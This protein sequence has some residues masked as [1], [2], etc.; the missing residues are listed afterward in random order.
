MFGLGRKIYSAHV[1]LAKL[2]RLHEAL[3][4]PKDKERVVIDALTF[5]A[6][7]RAKN[8][9]I[10][11]SHSSAL[12]GIVD[13]I[14]DLG[15]PVRITREEFEQ[16]CQQHSEDSFPSGQGLVAHIASVSRRDILA[17]FDTIGFRVKSGQ[18]ARTQ[19]IPALEPKIMELL[20]SPD[21]TLKEL[22]AIISLI[23]ALKISNESM[24]RLL[25]D[26]LLAIPQAELTAGFHPAIA[27]KLL[28]DLGWSGLTHEKLVTESLVPVFEK[29]RNYQAITSALIIAGGLQG[30]ALP[31]LVAH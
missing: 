30:G 2:V 31:S 18:I 13:R 29:F 19:I 14:R 6:Q 26:A 1:N 8:F 17:L 23:S 7:V 27:L 21:V 9:K 24:F 11:S 10:S 28:Q 20:K 16:N 3:Q 15:T 25:V 4:N 22:A 5:L 12:L